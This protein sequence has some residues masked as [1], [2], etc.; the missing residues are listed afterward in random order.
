MTATAAGLN[1]QYLKAKFE[2]AHDYDTYVATGKPEQTDAWNKILDQA[3]LSTAQQSLIEGFTREM[4]IIVSSG[5]WCGDC[6][7]QGPLIERIARANPSKIKLR[8]VDRDEHADLAEQITVCGGKRVPVAILAAEDFEPC[9]IFGDRTLSRYRAMA[10]RQLGA[11]CQI[12]GAP[13]ADDELAATLQDW[14]N[15]IERVQIMLRLSARL[16]QKHGD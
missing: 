2:A 9:S 1:A 11:S 3:K 6:V 10:A 7:Q 14:L 4:H 8:F 12:P 16:R 15:E 5:V 13:V